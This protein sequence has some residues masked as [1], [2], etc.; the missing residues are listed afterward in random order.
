MNKLKLRLDDIRVNGFEVL[1]LAE[2]GLG[3]VK[4]AEALITAVT[5][6]QQDTCWDGSCGTGVP[7]RQCP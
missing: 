7:C 5:R 2:Y 6:C 1:P 4:G 3:T